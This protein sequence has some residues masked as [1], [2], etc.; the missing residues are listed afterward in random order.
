MII[1][2]CGHS[3]VLEI[4][5]VE[6]WLSKTTEELIMKGAKTFYLGGYGEFDI[7]CKKV[8]LKHKKNYPNIELLLIVPYLKHKMYT[9][10][11][12]CTLYPEIENTP[13][14]FAIVARNKWMVEKCDVLVAYVKHDFGGASNTLKHAKRKKKE[15]I[16]FD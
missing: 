8:L 16:M 14:R 3:S 2:F 11:Y 13:P 5:K 6:N 7:L 9:E 1:T 10:G 4:E 12:D 15:I